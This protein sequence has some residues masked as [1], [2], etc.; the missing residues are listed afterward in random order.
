MNQEIKFKNRMITDSTNQKL[1]QSFRD[2]PDFDVELVLANS[3]IV[4]AHRVVLSMYSKY[5]RSVLGQ[6]APDTKFIGNMVYIK[7]CNN[8]V[9]L[10]CN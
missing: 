2:G 6:S 1:L 3:R 7:K 5:F 10:D 4:S 9:E 8:F